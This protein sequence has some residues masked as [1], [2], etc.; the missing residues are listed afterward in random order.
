MKK[1]EVTADEL[2]Q[3]HDWADADNAKKLES[4]F[5]DV[6]KKNIK[7]NTWYWYDFHKDLLFFNNGKR[8]NFVTYGFDTTG[9]FNENCGINT[10]GKH[11]I[12]ATESEILSHLTKEAEKRGFKEGAKATYTDSLNE[13]GAFEKG[14]AHKYRAYDD[15]FWYLNL[16]VYKQGKWATI[17]EQPKDVAK[18]L[19]EYSKHI[20]EI[21]HQIYLL[22]QQS[23]RIKEVL[24]GNR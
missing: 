4:K 21:K 17:I 6:F 20:A 2:K 8:G 19:G 10:D 9:R 11:W 14:Y 15:C 13:N 12:E 5:P 18:L 1:Y 16:K 3:F 24:N 7:L 22:D 23:E